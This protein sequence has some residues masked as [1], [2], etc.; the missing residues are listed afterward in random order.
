MIFG[1][2]CR[3]NELIGHLHFN[4]A[5]GSKAPDRRFPGSSHKSNKEQGGE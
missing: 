2:H 5:D 1:R 4:G 3:A